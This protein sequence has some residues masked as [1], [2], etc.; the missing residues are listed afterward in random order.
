VERDVVMRVSR[1]AAVL[2][3]LCA[4]AC[5]DVSTVDLGIE[6]LPDEDGRVR[7]AHNALGISGFWYAF[8][9]QY[10]QPKACTN[11]GLHD[12][13]ECSFVYSPEPLPKLDFPNSGGSM[14]TT[15]KAAMVLK[16]KPATE[17][18]LN[19]EHD[20]NTNDF[21]FMWGSGI[22]LDFGLSLPEAAEPTRNPVI[23]EDGRHVWDARA[24]GIVGIAF[25]FLQAEGQVNDKPF[26]RV[27]FPIALTTGFPLPEGRGTTSLGEYPILVQ[28]TDD[29]DF[30]IPGEPPSSEQHPLGSPFWGAPEVFTDSRKDVSPVRV[31]HNVVRFSEV[32]VVRFQDAQ[33]ADYQ[34]DPSRLLGVQFH[35]PTM[36]DRA[37]PYAFCI[38]NLTFL[39]E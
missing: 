39:R 15:G 28:D 21:S 9:D 18:E 34:F 5:F 3:A 2:V 23:E 13:S 33:A 7:P 19:C 12:P 38:S 29:E 36:D 31:G 14:C 6:V 16:C 24:H 1:A 27:E 20:G 30:V 35:V 4:T 37:L 11:I 17:L 26:L 32:G 22:G 10:D 8:G 25:D